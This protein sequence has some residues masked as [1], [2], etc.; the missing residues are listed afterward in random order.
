MADITE[1]ISQFTK[2]GVAQSNR[3]RVRFM[4]PIGIVNTYF[5]NTGS[6]QGVIESTQIELNRSGGID[7]LCHSCTLPSREL[8]SY[9]LKQFGPPHR[10][11]NTVSYM[12]ITF[13]FFSD[14]NL[15][16]RRYFEIWQTAVHNISSNTFNFYNEYVASIEIIVLDR[17]S[18]DGS[19]DDSLYSV[20]IYEAWPSSI[21]GVDYSY[22]NNNTPQSFMVT[23]QY[24]YWQ[25]NHDDTR[26]S[27]TV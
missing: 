18:A 9:D 24:K 10:M 20:N 11:P 6:A 5:T 2:G 26:Q 23:M 25:A 27:F 15:N 19:D 3:Y 14:S 1:F 22:A 17:E 8:Q 7:L 12:P 13:S 4:L 21:A 16:S